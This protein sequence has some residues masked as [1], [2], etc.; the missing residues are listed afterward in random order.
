MHLKKK[1]RMI[2]KLTLVLVILVILGFPRGNAY[3]EDWK[4]S[5]SGIPDV[6]SSRTKEE[7]CHLTIVANGCSTADREVFARRITDMYEENSFDSVRFSRDI[8]KY[9]DKVY[10]SVYLEKK[11][12]GRTAPEFEVIYSPKSGEIDVKS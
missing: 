10:M 9:P 4:R 6:V 5:Y 1:K 3:Y 7:E 12:V 8:G 2:T 11:D